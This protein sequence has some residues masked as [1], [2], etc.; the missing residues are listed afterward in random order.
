MRKLSYGIGLLLVVGLLMFGYYESYQL[1]QE[2]I[3]IET[4]NQLEPA[5]RIGEENGHVAV[6]RE[7]GV[8]YEYTDIELEMLPTEVA[9]EVR[10]GITL[11]NKKELYGFLEN[12]S[13]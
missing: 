13:S 8:V 2:K 1:H 3:A 6:Y 5:Y 12:Y 9:D 7:D 10:R 4:E 11:E